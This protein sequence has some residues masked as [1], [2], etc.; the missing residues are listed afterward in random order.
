MPN[1]DAP[2][3]KE[4][5]L[6]PRKSGILSDLNQLTP[7]NQ[8]VFRSARLTPGLVQE[9]LDLSKMSIYQKSLTVFNSVLEKA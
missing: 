3:L 9:E 6:T 5:S 2:D 4:H 8:E 1:P 7:E